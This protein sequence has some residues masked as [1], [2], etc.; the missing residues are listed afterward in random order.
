MASKPKLKSSTKHSTKDLIKVG[1]RDVFVDAD[2]AQK[3]R[4]VKPTTSRALV[5]RNGKYGVQGTGDIVLMSRISGR[6]KLDLLAEDLVERTK[7]AVAA[8]FDIEKCLQIAE[9]QYDAFLGDISHLHDHEM[10]I[11]IITDELQA[12]LRHDP[13]KP[14]PLKNPSYIANI[15]ATRI[16][17]QYML[18]S[19]WKI[20]R[21]AL[22]EL[23]NRGMS[24]KNFKALLKNDMKMRNL[25][26]SLFRMVE[27]M[28]DS[29]QQRFSVLALNSAHYARYFK[30]Q[31]NDDPT[32][33]Q[34]IVFDH[35]ELREAALSFIDSIII[36]LC[37]PKAPYPKFVLYQILHDAA[38]E[39]PKETKRFSQLMWDAVGDLSECVELHQLLENPL[40]VPEAEEWRDELS[41][42]PP[43]FDQWVDAQMISLKASEEIA[44]FK[45]LVFPL[46]KTTKRIV[47]DSMWMRID[48]N[49]FRITGKD[50]DDLW[51]LKGEGAT[52]Q[53]TS[54]FM[55]HVPENIVRHS[56]KTNKGKKPLAITDFAAGD[57][58]DE[59][60]P[61]TASN[62][63]DEIPGLQTVSNSSEDYSSADESESEINYLDDDSDDDI[64]YDTEEEEEIREL[65]RE[66]MD[67]AYEGDWF[68]SSEP[69]PER[70]G[71]GSNQQDNPFLKLLGSLRGQSNPCLIV[72]LLTRF[73][74]AHSGQKATVE[75]VTDEEESRTPAKKKKKKSKKKK[76]PSTTTTEDQ[77]ANGTTA[78]PSPVP[79]SGSKPPVLSPQSP[80][81]SKAKPTPLVSP[82]KPVKKAPTASVSKTKPAVPTISEASVPSFETT[83]SYGQSA[84]TYLSGFEPQRVKTKTRSDQ[85]SLFSKDDEKQQGGSGVMPKLG[86]EG[87][88][89]VMEQKEQKAA[90]SSWFSKLSNRANG[91]MHHLLRTSDDVKQG[92]GGMRWDDFVKLMTEMGFDYDP[93]TAGS[94]VR[95]VPPGKDDHPISFHKPHPKPY[96]EGWKLR[97]MAR[98]L[99]E[100]YGWDEEVFMSQAAS[101]IS[102]PEQD[103]I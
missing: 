79:L 40:L 98:R 75:E 11:N 41:R 33:D 45:D 99:K 6:E 24:N 96:I 17:N 69:L 54:F 9:S 74:A 47:L 7:K 65:L 68:G 66:A 13:N 102:E 19:A 12:Q 100:H 57:D 87:E 53:W 50:I 64:G 23:V 90:Q 34:E 37:F 56:S 26:L 85:A 67:V 29:Y 83:T 51:Q 60:G 89:R 71:A 63:S 28:V 103:D 72:M 35:S 10:F 78:S 82:A 91:L 18:T 15:I 42:M 5:L 59:M 32:D 70:S 30:K 52:P 20:V 38:E 84:R 14:D 3:L 44:N 92:K 46:T 58:S 4:D 27:L 43:E 48:Q 95:F 86:S 80:T 77:G 1:P 93:S 36:E 76:K 31:Q 97:G 22:R 25:Y 101:F 73:L 55:H 39:S 94:S 88:K 16:H 62:S 21:D 81:L 49:Y 8:P 2:T 61:Q